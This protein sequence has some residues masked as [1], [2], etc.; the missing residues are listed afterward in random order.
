MELCAGSINSVLTN[1]FMFSGTLKHGNTILHISAIS[2]H[3]YHL[4]IIN[5]HAHQEATQSSLSGTQDDC[6]WP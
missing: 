3:E 1:I 5:V 6:L 2:A 4:H